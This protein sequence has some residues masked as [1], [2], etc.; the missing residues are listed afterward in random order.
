[1]K[2]GDMKMRRWALVMAGG[3]VLAGPAMAN[4]GRISVRVGW[5][6]R[7]WVPPVYQER[8]RT[9]WV[10]PVYEVRVRTVWIGPAYEERWV[11]REVPAVVRTRCVPRY[12][13]RGRMIGYQ[14][15]KEVVQ[16]ARTVRQK[17]RVKV[18]N[19]HYK[20]IKERVL[21]RPGHRKVI[22][23]KVLVREGY[24][25][26]RHPPGRGRRK[27]LSVGFAFHT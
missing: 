14:T 23:K 21:V 12:D 7:V 16:P 11:E 9:V 4:A 26:V 10:E 13:R 24:Y 3:V 27:G 5:G 2:L 22:R 25:T 6:Q 20:R 17:V 18:G 15:I 8:V 19:G 1:M